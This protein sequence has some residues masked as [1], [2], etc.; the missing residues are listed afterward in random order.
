MGAVTTERPARIAIATAA[1]LRDVGGWSTGDGR[2]VRSG[3]VYRSAQLSRLHGE[4]LTAFADLGVRTVFDLRTAGEV[5]HQPDV[6]PEGTR[7]V[8]LDVLADAQHA[9]PA[10]LQ[11]IFEDPSRADEFLRE[12]QAERYFESAYR[13]FVT[14]PSART[15]YA[16]LFEGLATAEAPVLFHCATGK[17]RTGWATAVLFRLLGV[18]EEEI[19]EDYLLTNTELLPMVQPWMDQFA[20]AG[21]DPELL[22]P[23][24]GVQE[25]YLDAAFAQL[26]ESFGSVDA[27]LAEGLGLSEETVTSLQARLLTS[28]LGG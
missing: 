19:R 26:E 27:Y 2:R 16:R 14:L 6:L 17:D 24:L 12:G 18:P 3:V 21:G 22:V 13:D 28:P 7:A 5:A 1:N 11:Q 10:E 20:A 25:S 8:H 9:A 4:D 23:I 15:A